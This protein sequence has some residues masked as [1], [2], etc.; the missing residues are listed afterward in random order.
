MP[1]DLED[2]LGKIT[3]WDKSYD[4]SLNTDGTP[5]TNQQ[6]IDS[7]KNQ[8]KMVFR[9]MVKLGMPEE[10]ISETLQAILEETGLVAKE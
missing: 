4:D 6:K 3:R 8:F 1:K 10:E 2:A 7:T 5:Y 9:D